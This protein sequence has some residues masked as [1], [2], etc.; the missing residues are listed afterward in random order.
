MA[1]SETFQA[2]QNGVTKTITV[3]NPEGLPRENLAP[4]AKEA[5]TAYLK[6]SPTPTSQPEP[7]AP[8]P[9]AAPSILP[10][11][12]AGAATAVHGLGST[13]KLAGSAAPDTMVGR[14]LNDHADAV[15]SSVSMPANFVDPAAHAS[16]MLQSGRYLDALKDAPSLEANMLP[17]VGAVAAGSAAGGMMGGPVGAGIGGFATNAAMTA[18]PNV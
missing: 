14:F 13:M 12:R 3:P 7:S 17:Q 1:S 8:S 2:S 10:S 11:L 5:F 6:S 9:D 16:S 15:G 4:L 18:G